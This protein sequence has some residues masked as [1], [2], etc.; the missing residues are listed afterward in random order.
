MKKSRLMKSFSVLMICVFLVTAGLTGCGKKKTAEKTTKTKT[1][2]T[3]KNAKKDSTSV[4]TGLEVTKDERNMR[5]FAVMVENTK[6]AIPQYGLNNASIIYE[7]PVEGGI[8]RL[9][10]IFENTAGL[11]KIGNVRSCRP[12]Y[13]YIA[14]EYNAIYTHF[15][16]SKEGAEALS[17]GLVDEING[18]SSIG[19]KVFYRTSDK[20]APHN[21]YTSDAG[22]KTGAE[23]NG[24]SVTYNADEHKHFNFASAKK[25]NKLEKGTDCKTLNLYFFNNK[26]FFKYDASS[27]LYTRYEFGSEQI[28]KNTG[29]AITVS[30]II[31]QNVSS[32]KYDPNKGTLKLGV[33][34]SGE[35][36]FL[37]QGKV[38][39][40]TW[41]RSSE[42]DITHYYDADGKEIVLNPGKTWVSLIENNYAENNTF[43]AE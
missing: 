26:P 32:E 41:K 38:I 7:C 20:K 22:L 27:G 8:T 13:V 30:N 33:I 12:Y 3:V 15:G 21:A 25:L 37:T 6:D 18:L 42:K 9:M 10:P 36:K 17:L 19:G 16:Q 23:K 39:D 5:P 11:E 29:S 24:F 28:D 31:L 43:S 2:K 14:N 4:L 40:I 35:G 34:G 1:V